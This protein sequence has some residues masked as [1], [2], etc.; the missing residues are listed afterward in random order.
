M[1]KQIKLGNLRLAINSFPKTAKNVDKVYRS[2]FRY[3]EAT[4]GKNYSLVIGCFRIIIEFCKDN[5][6]ETNKKNE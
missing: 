2:G 6:C 1:Y 5:F 3:W 4:E